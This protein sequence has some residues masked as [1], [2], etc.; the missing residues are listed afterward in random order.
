MTD[1]RNFV[2]RQYVGPGFAVFL[3]VMLCQRIADAHDDAALYLSLQRQWIDGATDIMCGDDLVDL[4]FTR[5]HVD[6]AQG[7]LNTEAERDVHVAAATQWF[8]FRCE[9][10]ITG[11]NIGSGFRV[12][13]LPGRILRCEPHGIAADERLPTRG[14]RTAIGTVVRIPEQ[15]VHGA[16]LN[17]QFFGC[18]SCKY[19]RKALAHFSRGDAYFGS[20]SFIRIQPHFN[21]GAGF[22]GGATAEAGVLVGSG[23]TPGE[24]S[25]AFLPRPTKVVAPQIAF[26][27]VDAFIQPG[28]LTHDL[29]C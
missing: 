9:V 29:A 13:K 17:A 16:C 18:T 5:V 14:R 8:C 28:A 26:N 19:D 20:R 2:A 12:L 15:H 7:G 27:Q 10:V 22:V 24:A 1:T 11:H 25:I 3:D 21:F 6:L 23:E 4:H